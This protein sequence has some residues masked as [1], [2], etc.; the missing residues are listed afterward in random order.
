[1]PKPLPE[2]VP[3]TEEQKGEAEKYLAWAVTWSNSWVRAYPHLEADFRSAAMLGVVD[4]VQNFDPGRGVKLTT[5]IATCVHTRCGAVLRA[6]RRHCC[7]VGDEPLDPEG[8][9]DPYPGEPC[10]GETAE[11]LVGL[12]T[13]RTAE[14][15]RRHVYGGETFREIAASYGVTRQAAHYAV[16]AELRKLRDHPAALA[17]R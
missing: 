11:L 3:L 2:P 12:L 8:V 4:G 14:M 9:A 16:T 7:R 15:V 1:M 6:S 10:E 13:P 5:Y 17:A